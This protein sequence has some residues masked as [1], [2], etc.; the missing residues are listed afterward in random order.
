VA[1]QVRSP[2]ACARLSDLCFEGRWG[3]VG[4]HGRAAVDAY[5]EMSKLDVYALD[6][7]RRTTAVMA[8][9]D[10]LCRALDLASRMGDAA[11][12]ELAVAAIVKGAKESLAQERAEPGAALGL[13]E[14]LVDADRAESD[15]LLEAAH[16]RYAGDQWNM[17]KPCCCSFGGSAATRSADGRCSVLGSWP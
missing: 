15:E 7:G 10:W 16:R 5:L 2:L 12:S 1:D 6:E 3:N 17:I 11:R 4:E 13:I 8:R 14:A 9:V